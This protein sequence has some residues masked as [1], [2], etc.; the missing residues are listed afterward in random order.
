MLCLMILIVNHTYLLK[1]YFI[2][3]IYSGHG[4][5]PPASPTSSPPP[6]HK[7]KCVPFIP[8]SHLK[9]NG[10]QQQKNQISNRIGQKK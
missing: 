8:V 5:A 10:Q 9:T 2:H 7:A 1:I 6:L 3:T 4:S